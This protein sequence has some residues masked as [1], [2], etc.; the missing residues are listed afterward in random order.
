MAKVKYAGHGSEKRERKK[1]QA[2]RL[3]V[4]EH[5]ALVK[6]AE[7]AGMSIGAFIRHQALGDAGPRSVRR[8]SLDAVLI[9]KAI[10]QLNYVGNNLNQLTRLANMGDLDEPRELAPVLRKI[11]ETADAYMA[12]LGRD[13]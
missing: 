7:Q 2:I 13:P 8:L 10:G 4:E 6:R 11:D 9:R 3:T 5:A 1:L 12:A